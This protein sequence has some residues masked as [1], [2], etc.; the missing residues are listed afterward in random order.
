[1]NRPRRR[2]QAGTIHHVILKGHN[3]GNIF[4][5]DKDCHNFL[6]SLSRQARTWDCTLH[7][8]CLMRNHIHLILSVQ[9]N[10]RMG[11][12]L[13][14]AAGRH[15]QRM[16]Q[17]LG[18]SGS[19]W[20]GRYWSEP[21]EDDQRIATCHLYIESNPVRAGLVEEPQH[22]MWSSYLAHA[23]GDPNPHVTPTLWYQGLATTSSGRQDAY[24]Q[25]MADYLTAW[26]VR[27]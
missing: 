14:V 1:M 19:L 16:N 2:D 6:D 9:R 27:T 26:R 22:Y 20:I 11:R 12:V 18:R 17:Q 13:K 21:M 10:G 4:C 8:Y 15:T 7:A 3:R 5:H 24:R 23:H 25:L